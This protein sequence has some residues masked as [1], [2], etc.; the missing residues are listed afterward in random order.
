[1]VFYI[2]YR[3]SKD[4]RNRSLISKRLKSLGCRPLCKSFWE[5]DEKHVNDA[6]KIVQGNQP[7]LLKRTRE[8]MDKPKFDEEGNLIDLGS[9][10]V[11][12]FYNAEKN[13]KEKIRRLLN[14]MPYI[15]LCR[16]VYAFCQ[17]YSRYDRNGNLPSLN[18]FLKLVKE[19]DK[20]ARILL[21]VRIMNTSSIEMLL[22]KTRERIKREVEETFEEYRN[23]SQKIQEKKIDQK[24]LSEEEKKLY[25][26]FSSI[27]RI[28][29]FYEKWLRISFTNDLV[30]IYSVMRKLK[31]LKLMET[32][33]NSM[34]AAYNFGQ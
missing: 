31:S 17:Y 16:S 22:K 21:R 2:I 30:K 27:R 1:M 4:C 26:R 10:I 9:L 32:T 28:A 34:E 7:I 13:E 33:V 8:V 24:Q 15:R 3:A 20:D 29:K 12:L 18:R 11:V 23:L 19:I 14:H 6:L 25:K 5:V